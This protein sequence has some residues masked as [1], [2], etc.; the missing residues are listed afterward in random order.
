MALFSTI[1]RLALFLLLSLALVAALAAPQPPSG[2]PRIAGPV[3]EAA[4]VPLPGNLHTLALPAGDQGA[5]DPALPTG[6]MLLLLARSP[7]QESTLQDFLR[8]AHTPGDPAFH[9]WLKPAEFARL[10]GPAASDLAAVTAW[11]ESHGLTVNKLH[12]GSIEFSGTAA[13]LSEAFHT[14]LHRYLVH[15]ESHLAAAAEPSIPAALAPVL[16]GLA[17]LNDFQP[18]PQ[19]KLLG[20]AAF[21]AK[22]HLATPTWTY[23]ASS[24]ASYALAPGDFATQYDIKPVYATGIT[25]AGQSIAI[26]SASNIDLSLVQAYQS[27][28]GL[29]ANLPVVL[30]DGQDPGQN[31]AALEAYLDVEIAGSVAPKA[32]ILLYTS[33]GSAL[34]NGL[35]LAALR[36][37]EDDQAGLISLSYGE[38]EAELGQGGNAFWSA[39]WQ[40][41]AAQGQ[42]VFISSGDSGSASCDSPAQASAYAGLAVNGIA[43]TPYNVAVGGTD[44]YY[45]QYASGS[46]AV[47]SQLAGYWSSP[48]TAPAVSLLKPVPEQ[49]WNDFFG[50]N[51]ADGGN[52]STL[53]TQT[54][55]AGGGGSSSAALYSSSGAAGYPKP[56]WQSGAGVPADKLRDLPDLALFA[57]NGFNSSFYPICANPGDCANLNPSGA[58][59]I[60]A[61]GGTSAAAPAMAA[62]QAL[63]NQ[64]NASWSGQ[65]DFVYYPLAAKQPSVFRDIS[66]GTN[67]VACY[68]GTSNCVSGSLL[69]Y[70]VESGYPATTG[71]DQATGLG[72]VDVAN[73]IK[74]WSS[75]SF[76]PTTTTLAVSPST[77]VHGK[78][79]TVTATVAPASSTGTPTGSIALTAADGLPG[80][81][82][83]DNL[84]L[85]A[86]SVYAPICNLPGGTYQLTA[87]YSGDST[88]AASKSAPLTVT[89]TP[90]TGTLQSTGWAW[91]P[92]DLNLYP[93]S[94]GMTVP[95]GAQILLD[96]QLVSVNATL[97]GQPT[98]ATGAIT[99]TDRTASSTTTSTQPLNVA[100]L[101]EWATGIFAPGAH[102]IGESYSGD[103]SYASA[104][105]PTAASF[106]IIPGSTTLTVTPLATTVAA[107]SSLTVQVQMA[108]GY[109]PLAGTLPTGNVTV[110]LGPLTSSALL[111]PFGPTGSSTL[112]AIVSFANLPP[113]ILPVSASYPGDGNWL[114]SAANGP[115]VIALSAKP[116]PT[117]A[118]TASSLSPAPSQTLTLTAAVAAPSGKPAPTGTVLFSGDA[119]TLSYAATLA[120]GSASV[121]FPAFAAANGVNLFTAVYQGDSN[122]SP[123]T[124]NPVSVSIP[125]TDFSL[126]TPTPELAI[127]P[128]KSATAVLQLNPINGFTGTV[129]LATPASSASGAVSAALSNP[130][131]AVTGP[132]IC[133]LTLSVSGSIA[134]GVYPV[135]LTASSG[136]HVH[137]AQILVAALTAA[138]P[139]FNPPAGAYTSAQ[140][141][142]LSSPTSAAV[143]YFTTNGATPTSSSTRY[144]TPIPVPAT[145]TIQ[146]IAIAPSYLP[147]PVAS[148]TFTINRPAATPVFAPPAATYSTPQSVTLTCSTPG[149]VLY[150]TTNGTAPSP[151]ST[152]YTGPIP[153]SATQTIKAI[154]VAQGYSQ[155]ATATATYTIN[156]PIAAAPK[157]TPPAGTYSAPQS[158]TISDST[159]NAAIYYTTNGTVPTA[160]ST[161][162]TAAIPVSATQ[163]IQAIAIATNYQQSPVTTATYTINLPIT[164][165][166]K[167]SPSAGT[168]SAA[169][170]VSLSDTTA[171][172]TIYYTTNGTAP[173]TSSTKYTG[174]ISVSSTQTIQAMAI[175]QNYTQSAVATATYTI[176]LPV[177]ANP[178][179]TP[180]AGT[181]AAAQTVTISDTTAKAAIYYTTNGTAPTTSSTKYTAPFKVSVTQTI[182]AIAVAPGLAPSAV[183]SAAY[184]ISA[185]AGHVL[186]RIS[187]KPAS[188]PPAA[189]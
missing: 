127:A 29:P 160:S 5:V 4:R 153:V 145:E 19:F 27:L 140:S 1:A 107:A 150:Y 35:A 11:I 94:P 3:N 6:R 16:A 39:L 79:A 155:S 67:Q 141:V 86:A 49:V 7:A 134:R 117:V 184:T 173:T 85:T 179:F 8:A 95:Y 96:A 58:V 10:F 119:Q 75:V 81:T 172:A 52:P 82:G 88:F 108:T 106:T 48:T 161:R 56:A 54:I 13:Q 110:T 175:A 149:A 157:F 17:S 41:A 65:A 120:A 64:S 144:T 136:G 109:L 9:R 159:T 167:F 112:Q 26:V 84:P 111:Q 128:G 33:A 20:S 154:A 101:A 90:E 170:T 174:A 89:V 23:P 43:S 166:P 177:T 121:S 80:S 18:Q 73:L 45:S 156:L 158:V 133:L 181:Y 148:A 189:K 30:V 113:G 55:A 62:I 69:S 36:A 15:G 44:F 118:L 99:F 126:T 185:P 164:A 46:S 135:T 171:K 151:A 71:Y 78:T 83:L 130:T 63:V 77:L 50:L 188:D 105:L 182:K 146:A 123:A 34:T 169:Q 2:L 47:A 115:T 97:S 28:F 176:N 162:Y 138:P 102:T 168:Y 152:R 132:T 163:T 57:A 104:S 186:P 21:N 70:W 114:P 38:C 32:T 103:P 68:A 22:T 51:L 42:S 180:P 143:L 124:S 142:T 139:A 91:N 178:K 98:P 53:S 66:T 137:T 147:S 40:Q 100:G 31:A 165:T 129:T 24:G 59:V 116:T 122:Y 125:Q 14:G 92:A 93:L 131:A 183:V 25:G 61:V 87:L 72:S 187:I 74:Y 76:K 12:A 37:V 60:T